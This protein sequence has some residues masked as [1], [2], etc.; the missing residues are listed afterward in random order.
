MKSRDTPRNRDAVDEFRPPSPPTDDPEN[1]TRENGFLELAAYA[2]DPADGDW[3]DILLSAIRAGHRRIYLNDRRFSFAMGA[4][5]IT[6]PCKLTFGANHEVAW[7]GPSQGARKGSILAFRGATDVSITGPNIVGVPMMNVSGGRLANCH[8]FIASSGLAEP[9]VVIDGGE[10]YCD[11]SGH[12]DGY[13]DYPVPDDNNGN[14]PPRDIGVVRFKIVGGKIVGGAVVSP[15]AGYVERPRRGRL[16]AIMLG[17]T[18]PTTSINLVECINPKVSNVRQTYGRG[19]VRIWGGVG[20]R[21]LTGRA[22]DIGSAAHG[23][24]IGPTD[25]VLVSRWDIKGVH[26]GIYHA[27]GIS[28]IQPPFARKDDDKD[29]VSSRVRIT[30]SVVDDV[31]AGSC[32][33]AVVCGLRDIRFERNTAIQR[34]TG[35]F[36][37]MQI[38]L[39]RPSKDPKNRG[40]GVRG[41]VYRDNRAVHHVTGGLAVDF[42]NNSKW[43]DFEVD[44]DR[45]NTIECQAETDVRRDNHQPYGLR[46]ANISGG[47]IA[48]TILF[49]PVGI[50][51]GGPTG[52]TVFSPHILRCRIGILSDEGDAQPPIVVRDAEIHASEVGG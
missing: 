36:F 5:V 46:T 3:T 28:L 26:G 22:R 29:P 7:A 44:F 50:R 51:A 20:A 35:A 1:P 24:Q 16:A 17:A 23:V 41:V 18:F 2:K 8:C 37:C 9:V 45:S 6:Q 25:D 42:Q 49:A 52:R 19:V 11:A 39:G 21:I 48:P 14:L 43:D 33:D 15:G 12:R 13:F 47:A 32:F 34:R 31:N 38:K 40:G 27:A 30:D 10:G 4:R